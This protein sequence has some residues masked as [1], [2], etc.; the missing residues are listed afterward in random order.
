MFRIDIAPQ[1]KFIQRT[2]WKNALTIRD[3]HDDEVR[4][5]ETEAFVALRRVKPQ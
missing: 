4:R 1:A 5:I 3:A 2:S